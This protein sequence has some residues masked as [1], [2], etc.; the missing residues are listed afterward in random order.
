MRVT[1]LAVALALLA[2]PLAAEAQQA[3]K[4]YRIGVLSSGGAEQER[5]LQAALREHLRERGW[6][7][8][9]N[10]IVEWRYAEGK[11]ERAAEL[12]NELV[13]LQP[14]LLM[15]RGGPVTTAAKRAS[16]TLPIVMW[17]VT[18]PVGI[19]A[20][21]SLARPG[22]NVTGLSDDP[23]PETVGK[24][25]QLVKEIAPTVT[26]VAFLTR[27]APSDIVPRV[28]SYENALEAGAKTL[29][30]SVKWWRLQGPDD[31]DRAFPE[32]TREGFRALYVDYVPV[33]W[34]HRRQILDLAS[35]HR[36]PAIY[37]H[38]TYA[39]DGGL[40]AYGED[41]REVPQRLAVYLDR[42]LKGARPA[43]LPVE[44][45]TKVE[46]VLNLKTAKALGLT[47]PPSLLARADQVIE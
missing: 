9:Q 3:G 40:M 32:I 6:V 43:D 13:R 18:D 15:T 8:G 19:G 39:L 26:K 10:L 42:I 37:T 16:A 30:L 44:Q 11:Y 27:I 14:D 2:A 21:A 35:R 47:I 46:L 38:R 41:E 31:I 17:S 1:A 36:L 24:R 29:G 5:F 45:P 23:S 25:L 28:T 12:V 20:V 34:T 4:V 7:E 22:G 33:T